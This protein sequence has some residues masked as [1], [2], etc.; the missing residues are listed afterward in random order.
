MTNLSQTESVQ[1]WL[2]VD[3]LTKR[4]G[5][6]TAVSNCSFVVRKGETVA[7]VGPS[8]SGKTTL[9]R[10][11][12]YLEKPDAGTIFLKGEA[13]GKRLTNRKQEW[14][15]LPEKAIAKQ[16]QH[17]GFVFQRFNLFAHLSALDNV[18]IGPQRVLN[19]PRSA[20]RELARRQLER[21]FL[22]DH[23][24]KRPHQLSGGQQQRVAIARSLAMS[25]DL[26]LFDEPT[27]ALDPELVNEVLEVMRGL[28]R[29]GITMAVVSH[30]MSF[31]RQV[32]H[33]V[34]FMDG[35]TIVERGTPDAIFDR[36]QEPRTQ[37][38]LA[39]VLT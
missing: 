9:L 5:K 27:S 2:Q 34:L 11:I 14:K 7:I 32:A 6:S 10:C 20:A 28:V 17:I 21:V 8:G 22:H 25:P 12:N 29:D 23:V 26:I 39:N 24:H 4:Y 1:P 36:P 18:A 13:I 38:F 19:M 3:K 16:R 30:E 37:R 35:G 33:Q 15:P 31:A